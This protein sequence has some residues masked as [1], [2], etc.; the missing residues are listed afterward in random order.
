ML[1][2]PTCSVTQH[3]LLAYESYKRRQPERPRARA[4]LIQMKQHHHL[5]ENWEKCRF[6]SNALSHHST[7][8]PAGYPAGLDENA[9]CP[10]II[11]GS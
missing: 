2:K 7:G 11:I 1:F 4:V 9:L 10:R 5:L 3:S 6:P 8:K